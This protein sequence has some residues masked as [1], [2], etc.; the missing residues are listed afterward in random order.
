MLSKS[1]E[2]VSR[3]L[4]NTFLTTDNNKWPI[5]LIKEMDLF[6]TEPRLSRL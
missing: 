2:M 1:L 4:F 5:V 3:I 6:R